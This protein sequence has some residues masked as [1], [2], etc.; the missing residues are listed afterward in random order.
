MTNFTRSVLKALL[1]AVI[2][3]TVLIF[4]FAFIA[5]KSEDPAKLLPTLGMIAFFVSCFTG[6]A[7]AR[8]R[9]GN[10]LNS[11]VFACIYIFLCFALSLI[12]GGDRETGKI[13]LTYLGGIASA[14][15][16]GILFAGGRQKKPKGLKKYKRIRNVEFGMRN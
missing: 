1:A 12:F 14:V 5:Y 15:L 2:A 10:I 13:L 16:G 11:L 6:G 8:R 7:A 3:A 9:E 4:V